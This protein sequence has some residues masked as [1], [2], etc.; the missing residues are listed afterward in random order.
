[1]S[2]YIKIRSELRKLD[3]GIFQIMLFSRVRVD[4]SRGRNDIRTTPLPPVFDRFYFC[5]E[6]VSNSLLDMIAVV[7]MLRSFAGNKFTPGE[8]YSV[9]K[10][11]FK[12]VTHNESPHLKIYLNNEHVY[13]DKVECA[14][15]QAK[16]SK[17]IAPCSLYN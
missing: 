4:E 10:L 3:T 12:L 2:D 9:Y 16:I 11:K 6:F 13:L 8:T 15:E 7:E 17:I 1:M 14:I 5:Y